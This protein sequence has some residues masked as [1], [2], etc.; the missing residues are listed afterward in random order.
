[1][2]TDDSTGAEGGR[3]DRASRRGQV[4]SVGVVGSVALG[5]ERLE[6]RNDVRHCRPLAWVL[7]PHPLQQVYRLIAPVL[8]ETSDGRAPLLG[9]DGIVDV[10]LVVAFPGVFLWPIRPSPS[11]R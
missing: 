4:L 5:D 1:V 6:I 2:T 11:R 9:A 10:M 8:A 7:M 3:V